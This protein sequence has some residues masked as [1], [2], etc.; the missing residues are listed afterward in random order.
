[1]SRTIH[2][3]ARKANSTVAIIGA[4]IAGLCTGCY[5]QMNGYQAHI[6]EMHTKPGGLCTAWNRKGYTIDAC[7]HWLTGTRPGSSLYKLWREIGLIQDLDLV[8]LHEFM[9]MEFPDAAPI[10]FYAD[11]DRLLPHLL[12]TAP[13]DGKLIRRLVA[14]AKRMARV[15]LP[16]D[17]PPQDIMGVGTRLQTMPRMLPLLGPLR[18]WNTLTM[19]QLAAR[20]HNPRLRTAFQELMMPEASA[21]TLIMML[22]WFHARQAG[23]PLGGSL[24][25]AEAV[26]GRFMALGGH[27][28]Y[29]ARVSEILVERDRAIGLRFANGA[30]ERADVVVSAADAHATIFDM[31][32]GRYVDDTVR[33]WFESFP[34]FPPLVFMGIGVNRTF[35][36]EPRLVSGSNLGLTQPIR[37]GD[38]TIHRLNYHIHNYDPTLA[39]AGKTVITCSF[40]V[41]YEYWRE[42]S[43]DR[44]RYE[45]EKQAVAD[46]VVKALDRRFPGLAEQVEMVDVATPATWERYTGNWHAS[47]EG[48]LPTPA[49]ITIEMR[50]T[51]PGLESFYMAGQWLAPGGGLPAG[52]MTGRQVVQL[53][54]HED[55]R[56][57]RAPAS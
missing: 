5:A 49:N 6:Y 27:I 8:D 52:V 46:A 18:R 40:P 30:Q 20:V 29:Q 10:I 42:L 56:R 17:L 14:D 32:K 23:Y 53:M 15:E 28:D 24:P 2:S 33:G 31:L 51:L 45:Q 4:G 19:A 9:R 47:F 11:L 7:I 48:W 39:P 22:S 16:S 12:E 44:E 38:T 41:G 43:L 37:V 21:L 34:P 25:L 36:E 50:K 57:F 35:P 54:C 1:M 55:G 13:E 26:A 3:A